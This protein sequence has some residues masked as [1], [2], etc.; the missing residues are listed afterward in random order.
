M[1]D[2]E[3]L[4]SRCCL[5]LLLPLRLFLWLRKNSTL[6]QSI[7]FCTLIWSLRY[8]VVSERFQPVSCDLAILYLVYKSAEKH[9]EVVE[10]V[11]HFGKRG[12]LWTMFIERFLFYLY[13]SSDIFFSKDS[14]CWWKLS[15][16]NIALQIGKLPHNNTVFQPWGVSHPPHLPQQLRPWLESTMVKSKALNKELTVIDEAGIEMFNA[17]RLVI[18][19]NIW[20]Y[21]KNHME[22]KITKIWL[23]YKE[24]LIQTKITW[25][26]LAETFHLVK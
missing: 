6:L 11:I 13:F 8:F 24:G 22:C 19:R 23:A 9:V 12:G 3:N 26:W 15:M 14:K 21:I 2:N 18:S 1:K 10:Q 7:H 4:L 16:Q 5:S 20:N 17:T 25:S